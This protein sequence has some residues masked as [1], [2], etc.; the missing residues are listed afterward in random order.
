MKPNVKKAALIASLVLNALFTALA[1]LALS[2]PVS[3]ISYLRPE[4]GGLAAAAL[5]CVPASGSAAFNAVE[6]ALKPQQKATLQFSFVYG[7]KQSDLLIDA[8]YDPAI[9]AVR[10]TGYG[11]AIEA[12]AEGETVLQTVGPGGVKDIALVRVLP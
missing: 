1:I 4:N 8:L 9:I 6:I 10:P 3:S 11:V 5:A 12:L 7:R 2:S